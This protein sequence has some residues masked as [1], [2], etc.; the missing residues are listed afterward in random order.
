MNIKHKLGLPYMG[1]KRKLA[2]QIVDKI[3]E[4]NP[5]DNWIRN[6][7][8]QIFLSE[9]DAPFKVIL[10]MPHRSSLSAT[11]NKKTVEKLYIKDIK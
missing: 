2:K 11:H 8:F 7:P 1:S 4:Y 10:E 3:L 6:N 9:Y 5:E